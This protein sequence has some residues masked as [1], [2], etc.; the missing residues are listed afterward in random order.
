MSVHILLILWI[1]FWGILSS[2]TSREIL[3]DQ[4]TYEKRA[5]T[6]V[7]FCTFSFLIVLAG[8]RSGM[9][10]TYAYIRA[11]EGLP[12]SLNEISSYISSL[13]KSK[14]FYAAS[15]VI[16]SL[17]STDYHIWFLIISIISGTCVMITLKNKG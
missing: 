12:D 10:D 5:N 13:E 1:V 16:K 8:L 6:I 14:G 15:I 3:V 11:F 17:I 4:G 9:A 2:V 7:A